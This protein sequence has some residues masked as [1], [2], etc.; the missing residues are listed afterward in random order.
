MAP[1]TNSF[2]SR[3]SLQQVV[4]PTVPV[5]ATRGQYSMMAKVAK[6]GVFSPAV[7]AAK[8]VLGDKELNKVRGKGIALH[9]QAI[10]EFCQYI[11]TS[12]QLRSRIIKLAKTN[13]DTLGFL[14]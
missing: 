11:G 12:T 13:G 5:T 7:F 9:S 6:F 14:V 4:A 1:A 2:V 10:T 8:V 3:P